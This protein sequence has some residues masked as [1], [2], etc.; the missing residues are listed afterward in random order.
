MGGGVQAATPD[1]SVTPQLIHQHTPDTAV[2]PTPEVSAEPTEPAVSPTELPEPTPDVTEGPHADGG[3]LIALTFDDG[4]SATVTD[5]ILDVLE[6]YGAK[7]TFFVLGENAERFRSKLQRAHEL[8]CEI[9]NHTYSH[10]YLDKLSAEE[11]RAQIDPVDAIVREVTGA[12]A[13][14]FRPPGGR[15]DKGTF[16]V[17][18]VGRPC[19]LW[20]IDTRDWES[21]DRDS[22]VANVLN[23]AAD[24]DI[25]LMHDL[26]LSTAEA[27]ELIVPALMER[28]FTLVTVS[29]L[30]AART[31]SAVPRVYRSLRP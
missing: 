7:A 13:P 6:E 11:I 27:V 30:I 1:V 8:G 25:V 31:E 23:D 4:P 20:S 28:G 10:K 24:G 19:I 26:Y 16:V 17:D 9:G 5:M 29:E 15:L 14:T 21:K 18:T 3:K 22:V 12:D 2:S